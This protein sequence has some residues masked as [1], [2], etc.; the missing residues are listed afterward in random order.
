M[1]GS[2]PRKLL[3]LESLH[4]NRR[5]PAVAIVVCNIAISLI[6]IVSGHQSGNSAACNSPQQPDLKCN[7]ALVANG[8]FLLHGLIPRLRVVAFAGVD[9]VALL[10][11]DDLDFPEFSIPVLVLRVVAETVLLMEFV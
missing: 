1:P 6:V 3:L 5:T 11:G 10:L 7:A 9:F 2:A 4:W 8:V